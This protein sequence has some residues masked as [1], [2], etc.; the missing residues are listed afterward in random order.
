M[1]NYVIVDNWVDFVK[2]KIEDDIENLLSDYMTEFNE[3]ENVEMV[4]SDMDLS[5]TFFE[6]IS[7][8][9]SIGEG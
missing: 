7:E 1:E 2:D 8:L 9:Y 6:L 3:T 5:H 4:I